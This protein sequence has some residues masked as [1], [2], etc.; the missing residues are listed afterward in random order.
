MG[1]R[2]G[3]FAALI[4]LTATAWGHG[5][6]R[7]GPHGGF[8]RMPGS[9]HTEIVPTG[10]DKIKVYLLDMNWENPSVRDSSVTAS[11]SGKKRL[12]AR[13]VQEKDFFT[14]TFAPGF[15]SKSGELRIEA[16]REGQSGKPA[17]YALPLDR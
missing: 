11:W 14:C 17:L 3:I 13:C 5:E 16:R 12:V 8:I 10:K 15:D 6:E 4:L 7:P 1:K 9:F 2:S